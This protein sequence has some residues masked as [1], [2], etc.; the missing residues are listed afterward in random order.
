M[1]LHQQHQQQKP[2]PSLSHNLYKFFFKLSENG[3]SCIV[4]QIK[5]SRLIQLFCAHR[6]NK[7]V[8]NDTL[9]VC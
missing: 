8:C 9:Y 6:E 7:F 2:F 3:V 1:P 4:I 5:L